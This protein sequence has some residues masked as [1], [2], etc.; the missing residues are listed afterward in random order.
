MLTPARTPRSKALPRQPLAQRLRLAVFELFYGPAAA[1]YD[2]LAAWAFLGEWQRWQRAVLP[3]LP[4]RGLVVE[5]GAGTA[6]L[7]AAGASPARDWLAVEP[8]AAMLRV[9]SRR[10]RQPGARFWLVRA[11]GQRL[12][13]ADGAADAVLATFPAPYIGRPTTV[14]EIRRVLRP[15][16]AV[17]IVLDG[18]LAPDGL[19][20]RCRRRALRLFYGRAYDRIE[21]IPFALPG[22]DGEVATIPTAHGAAEVYVGRPARPTSTSLR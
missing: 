20:R 18:R 19:G 8:S 2:R 10:A 14:A 12:P 22:F 9:A 4:E 1:H 16:G 21:P 15:G 13:L 11:T 7:A 6:A 5:L 3:L 17:V